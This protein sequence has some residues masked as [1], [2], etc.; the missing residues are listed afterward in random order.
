MTVAE[1]DRVTDEI[2]DEVFGLGPLEQLAQRPDRQRRDGERFRQRLCGARR[3]NWWKPMSAFKDQAH[4]RMIIDRVVSNVG[5][6]IDDSSPIVDARLEDG[7]RVCA[8]IPPSL[9]H[10]PYCLYSPL[11]QE[12]AHH[13]R[14]DP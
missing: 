9:A 13:G 3:A 14:S 2:L 5:R 11:R 4:L 6:R 8:V 12:T 1:R 10:R 7:S